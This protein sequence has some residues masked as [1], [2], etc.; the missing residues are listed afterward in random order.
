M[1]EATI[2]TVI[3]GRNEGDRLRACLA[4]VLPFIQAA[5]YVDSGSTDGSV[6]MAKAMGAEVLDLDMA[7]PFTAARARNEGYR[8]L[9]ALH[10][11][12]QW[13]QFVDGDCEVVTGWIDAARQYLESHPEC[14]VACGRRRERFPE[15]SVYNRMCDLEWGTPVG[16]ALSCGGDALFRTVALIQV[17]GFRDGLIAGEE[18]ELCLRL[19][20]SGWRIHR[21][22]QEMTRHDAAITRWSQWWRRTVRAGHAFAEG[23]WLHGASADRH[24]V[25]ETFRAILWGGLLP[26]AIALLGLLVNPSAWLLALIYPAQWLRLCLRDRSP[27]IAFFTVAGKFAEAQGVLK[28]LLTRLFG[29]T[30]R[31]IEY[32]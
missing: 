25:R 13:V 3:I 16:D 17:G 24:W 1:P 5:V 14:A 26:L 7:T 4:S 29:R 22:D 18:P 12:I 10:P 27:L 9:L 30:G 20:R 8:R 2:G 31:L 15:R 21:L 23:A 11:E 28:F 19:R 32:K 6:G